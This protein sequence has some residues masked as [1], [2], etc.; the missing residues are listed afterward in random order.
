[1]IRLCVAAID[2][3]LDGV[4][5][6]ARWLAIPLVLILFLQWPLRDLVKGWSREANDFGQCLFALFVAVA[7]TAATRSRRHLAVDTLS[8]GFPARTKRVLTLILL[9]AGLVPWA[10][11]LLVAGWPA[12]TASILQRET[13]PDTGNPGYFMIRLAGWVLALLVLLQAVREGLRDHADSRE[14]RP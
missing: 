10:G 5:R 2:R 12:L 14:P 3:A 9:I 6:G 11:F 7:V 1:M 13:F 8:H 4:V